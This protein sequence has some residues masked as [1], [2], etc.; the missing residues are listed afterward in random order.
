MPASVRPS[1]CLSSVRPS[2]G[3]G[4]SVGRCVKYRRKIRE[5]TVKTDV[6][7]KCRLNVSVRVCMRLCVR[8]IK[9][10]PFIP[11]TTTTGSVR[12][13]SV[14]VSGPSGSARFS[15]FCRRYLVL[16]FLSEIS[17]FPSFEPNATNTLRRP[18]HLPAHW[19]VCSLTA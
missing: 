17:S 12:S 13:G 1:V 2:V 18:L 15:F 8:T 11:T 6:C 5:N 16:V 14:R 4:F 10:Q 19:T 9:Y 3:P 7:E